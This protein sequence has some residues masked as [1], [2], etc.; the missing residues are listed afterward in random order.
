MEVND[1][2][3]NVKAFAL[4]CSIIWGAGLFFITWWI[5]MFDGASGDTTLIGQVY[6]GY[7]I[8][9]WGSFAGLIWGLADGFIGGLVFAWLYN[10][11][12]GNSETA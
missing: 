3:L 2:K 8:T 6:R 7:S 9:A 10:K 4:A 12:S 5:I 11:L 1:M